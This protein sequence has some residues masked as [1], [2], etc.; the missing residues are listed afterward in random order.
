MRHGERAAALNLSCVFQMSRAAPAAHLPVAFI[1]VAVGA[2]RASRHADII[3][4]VV[5]GGNSAQ[6][7]KPGIHGNP[8]IDQYGL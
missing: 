7:A 2:L 1:P 8:A 4:Q 6:S 5:A 3:G